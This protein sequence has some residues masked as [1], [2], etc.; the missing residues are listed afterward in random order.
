MFYFILFIFVYIIPYNSVIS[1]P[2]S[3]TSRK[4]NALGFLY[5]MVCIRFYFILFKFV[6]IIPYNNALS[7]PLS[8]TSRKGNAYGFLYRYYSLHISLYYLL[9]PLPFPLSPFL[10][11]SVLNCHYT[12]LNSGFCK[13]LSCL[14]EFR[15]KALH[16]N[17]SKYIQMRIKTE[18]E[19]TA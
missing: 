9:F 16:T 7:R 8:L 11:R 15:H 2:L 14:L 13:S 6:Y 10:C 4:D 5:I 3:L 19:R 1:R 12:C 17:T 18:M